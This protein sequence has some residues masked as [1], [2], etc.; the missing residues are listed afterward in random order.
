MGKL[1]PVEQVDRTG[2]ADLLDELSTL[3]DHNGIGQVA[4]LIRDGEYD[5]HEATQAF[6]RH[7][8][9]ATPA[10]DREG[11]VR[12]ERAVMV[13]PQCEGEGCYAD[14]VD[15]AACSTECTRCGSNGWIVDLASVTLPPVKQSAGWQPIS[16]APKDGTTI[17]GIFHAEIYPRIRPSRTDL[18]VWNGKQVPLR[19]PGI[20]EDPNDKPFDV[21][22]SIAAPVGAGGFPD[23]WIAGWQPLPAPPAIRSLDIT[24]MDSDEQV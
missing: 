22:W 20:F 5:E 15:D 4:D 16:T 13:C 9:E 8:I 14:G 3:L 23:E 10:V 17:W 12:N 1:Y 18:E 24:R 6:A 2:A 11:V 19:H 21:G 7:R